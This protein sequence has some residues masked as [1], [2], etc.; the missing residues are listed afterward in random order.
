MLDRWRAALAKAIAPKVGRRSYAAG[1]NSRLTAGWMASNGSADEELAASL[2]ALRSRSRALVRDAAYAKR[3]RSIVV[4][5]V[6][7][8]G[9]G[10]QACV[11]STRGE[12]FAR[13]NDSIEAAW[14][15]WCRADACHTGGT[16]HFADLE[17][18]LMA[19]VF[20]AGEVFVRKHYRRFGESKVPLALEVI[21]AERIADKFTLPSDAA[22]RPRLGIE[23]DDFGRPIAYW[24]RNRHPGDISFLGSQTDTIVRV[25]A[26]EMIHLRIVD[27]WP[28]V[29]GEPWLHAVAKRL[30]DMDGY[31][32]AE[33]VAAR[34][35]AVYVGVIESP[36]SP[37]LNEDT[38]RPEVTLEPG[39]TMHLQP[40]E[41]FNPYAP[42]RPN[43][44]MDPFMRLMLREVAAGVGVSYESLSRDYSQSNYSS[45]RLALL[46]DRDLWRVLQQWF[47]RS[48]REPLHRE[49]LRLAVMAGAVPA[50]SV[51][52]FALDMEKFSAVSF[53]PRG[54]GWVDP[55]K[56]VTAYK[57]AVLA[58]FTT[59]S[60]V[61][62]ATGGG[63]DIE[64]V[65]QQRRRELD[66]MESLDLEFDTKYEEPPEPAA[67]D[68][69]DPPDPPDGEDDSSTEDPPARVFSFGR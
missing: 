18:M 48:F 51:E 22:E 40:G 69:P 7:G 25:P 64:D 14:A 58:G 67:P 41:K 5:N 33:I 9:I 42:N 2:D 61:I 15:A 28:Q 21:E 37:E 63:M 17:R 56:E 20:E 3:A 54:W 55:T 59:V 10:M 31:S 19:Q 13:V 35:A 57:E 32:E 27:R 12:L 50:V 43:T 16:V 24:I 47:I 26:D 46:D 44:A 39:M 34:A 29:R 65:M 49:W 68:T 23:V 11:R 6:I 52:A 66:L 53:K 4:A 62:A 30:N 38:S 36:E 8:S 60:D 45:S 1:R